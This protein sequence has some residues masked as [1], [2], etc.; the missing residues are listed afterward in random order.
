MRETRAALGSIER[1]EYSWEIEELRR[2]VK[3]LKR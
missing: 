2:E 1:S 3:N